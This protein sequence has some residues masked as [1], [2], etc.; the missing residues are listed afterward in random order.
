MLFSD[1]KH[2][3]RPLPAALNEVVGLRSMLPEP[4]RHILY[5]YAIYASFLRGCAAEAGTWEGGSLFIIA[6]V[7]CEHKIYGFDTW[8]G[9]PAPTAEDLEGGGEIQLAMVE[10]WAKCEP[11][12]GL[13]AKFGDR[14]ELVRGLFAN[15]LP[16]VRDEQ[17]CL[18]HIDC[19]RYSS[20]VDCLEFFWPRLVSGGVMI[21]DD[22]GF[23]G[24]PGVTQAVDEYLADKIGEFSYKTTC[25]LYIIR[26]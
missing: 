16:V 15:T 18:V 10:G 13:L 26:R 14:V 12:T 19:D 22:Y 25:G 7:M 2:I 23:H 8:D 24:T 4:K 17:F 9:L 20:C 6:S 11:P 21:F 3:I 1:N 5:E